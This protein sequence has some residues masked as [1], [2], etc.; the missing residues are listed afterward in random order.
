MIK[1]TVIFLFVLSLIF[2]FTLYL[3]PSVHIYNKSGSV[4]YLYK[5]TGVKNVEPDIENAERSMRP[6]VINNNEHEKI[7][8]SWQDLYLNNSQLYLGWKVKSQKESFSNLNGGKIFDITTDVG[9]CSYSVCFGK[10]KET[11]EPLKGILCFKKIYV[12]PEK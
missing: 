12:S 2:M 7:N 3:K 9:C 5:S 11:I 10:E 1:N 8:L 6:I 4:I